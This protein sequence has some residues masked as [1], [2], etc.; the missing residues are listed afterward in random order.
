MNACLILRSIDKFENLKKA[1]EYMTLSYNGLV[2]SCPY[3]KFN[4]I[5]GS[6]I[7]VEKMKKMEKKGFGPFPTGYYK[8]QLKASNKE[9]NKIWEM[10]AYIEYRSPQDLNDKF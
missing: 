1:V 7:P 10:F 4:V 5:N 6:V 8:V 3:D 9:D 2:H